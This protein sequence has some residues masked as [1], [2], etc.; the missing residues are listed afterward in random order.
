MD[1]LEEL[2]VKLKGKVT[3]QIHVNANIGEST[4]HLTIKNYRQFRV[5]IFEYVNRYSIGLKVYSILHFSI[6]KPDFVFS[7][8]QPNKLKD[9]PCIVYT[10][11][12]IH[13]SPQNE[14]FQKFWDLFSELLNN[15]QLTS[16]EAVFFY[17]NKIKFALDSNRDVKES[18]DKIIDFL[19]ENNTIFKKKEARLKIDSNNIPDNLK[20]LLPLLKKYS[21]SDDSE[22]DELKEHMSSSQKTAIKDA[23]LPLMSEIETYLDSFGD[24]AF[25]HE[26]LLISALAELVAELRFS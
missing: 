19:S 20:V 15:F 6:N 24:E 12:N 16:S 4:R 23:V 22:R 18:L 25:T 8:S 11:E 13:V 3:K 21:V 9:F 26:A 1:Y 5:E 7:C 10:R 2:A 14:T 17:S